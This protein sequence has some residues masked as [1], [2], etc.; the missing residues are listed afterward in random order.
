MALLDKLKRLLPG[1]VA[2]SAADSARADKTLDTRIAVTGGFMIVTI[3]VAA[4]LVFVDAK[5]SDRS[6]SYAAIALEQQVI[7]QQ[8]AINALAAVAGDLTVFN[9]LASSQS[10]Y[11]RTVLILDNGDSPNNLPPLPGN[12]QLS[13]PH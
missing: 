2:G 3:V 5:N 11:N 13:I 4:L 9:Q 8:L 7:S 1:S 12:S 10:R 6:K